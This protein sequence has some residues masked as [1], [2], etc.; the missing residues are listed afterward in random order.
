LILPLLYGVADVVYVAAFVDYA[1]TPVGQYVLVNIANQFYLQYNRAKGFNIDTGQK[2][3][4]LLVTQDLTFSTELLAGLNVTDRYAITNFSGSELSLII[5]VCDRIP[6]NNIN[7]PDV[8][9]VSIAINVSVCRLVEPY[10]PTGAPAL[11]TTLRPQPRS[12][13]HPTRSVAPMVS[14]SSDN[15]TQSAILME[16]VSD[17]AVEAQT[18]PMNT[19]RHKA[20]ESPSRSDQIGS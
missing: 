6:G 10:M 13:P 2:A 9:I 16:S 3:N 4:L 8:M 17:P 1:L 15:F 20:P 19:K 14:H 11:G 5:E 12:T 18:Y 7:R